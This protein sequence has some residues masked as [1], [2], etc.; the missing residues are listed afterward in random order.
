VAYNWFF[1][2]DRTNEDECNKIFNVRDCIGDMCSTLGSKVREA[3]AELCLN[4]F[5]KNSAK[6]I[7]KAVMGLTSEGK[8]AE[9][10]VLKDNLLACS[11]V[12]I[13]NISTK[14]EETK[15]KLQLTVNLAIESTTKSQEEDAKRAAEQRD[16]EAKS[17]LQRKIIEDDSKSIELQKILYEKKTLTKLLEEQGGKEAEAKANA[18]KMMIE[19]ESKIRLAMDNKELQ[20]IKNQFKNEFEEMRH[21]IHIELEQSTNNLEIETKKKISEIETAKFDRIINSIGQDTLLQI[22]AAGPES[23]LA[24]L[25]SLGLNGFVMTDGENPLNLFNFAQNIADPTNN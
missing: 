2:V 3:V 20:K 12:D 1:D 21:S 13:K 17:F 23:Q 10:K 6:V 24:L 16:Q 25:K 5:H 19:S 7:R 18:S 11:N 4:D 15:A 22:A 8:I 14:N 9:K